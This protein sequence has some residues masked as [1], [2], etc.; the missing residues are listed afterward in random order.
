MRS[1]E[2]AALQESVGGFGGK[3]VTLAEGAL[4]SNDP[5]YYKVE[6]DRMATATPE[7]VKAA[8]QKWMSRPAFSLTYT[9]GERTEGG[10]NRG[11]AVT[12]GKV[13]APV[14]P[15]NYWNPALG[16]VGPTM[17]A[18]SSFADRS[19]FPAV[20]D[21]KALDFPANYPAWTAVGTPAL[22]ARGAAVE[23]RVV[24]MIGSGK[25]PKVSIPRPAK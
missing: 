3:A 22:L 19:K 2:T 23:M 8:A 4:Y 13:A 24:A 15:D 9:P 20:A 16:D 12:E 18:A 1:F 21:L 7:Q 11:G 14:Q 6:L 25:N 5:A 10:E 17:G